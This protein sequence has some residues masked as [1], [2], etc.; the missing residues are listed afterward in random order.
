MSEKDRN[1]R[2]Y[3]TSIFHGS[4]KYMMV[5]VAF[6]PMNLGFLICETNEIIY[7]LPITQYGCCEKKEEIFY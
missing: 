1:Q 7:P 3:L 4:A 6:P 2:I 5:T